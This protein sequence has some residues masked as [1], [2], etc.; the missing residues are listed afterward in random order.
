M[1]QGRNI[2][3]ELWKLFKRHKCFILQQFCALSNNKISQD[4]NNIWCSIE[5]LA[6]TEMSHFKS[7][8]ALFESLQLTTAEKTI[9]R[10]WQVVVDKLTSSLRL[11]LR[12]NIP[13][14]YIPLEQC[15]KYIPLLVYPYFSILLANNAI[16]CDY[17]VG[18]EKSLYQDYFPYNNLQLTFIFIWVRSLYF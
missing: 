6:F 3:L 11:L 8:F 1:K 15:L 9:I 2:C 14:N 12:F 5:F 16:A 18:A 13:Y 17:L 7:Y 10:L 4:G